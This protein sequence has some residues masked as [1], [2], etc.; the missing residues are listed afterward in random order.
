MINNLYDIRKEVESI[1]NKLQ[2]MVSEDNYDK[3]IEVVNGVKL[4]DSLICALGE[5]ENSL[6]EISHIKY[7][8]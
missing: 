1:K 4:N 5:L 8:E 7:G 6:V 3:I 2:L